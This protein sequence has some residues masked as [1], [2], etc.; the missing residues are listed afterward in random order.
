M[1]TKAA[2]DVWIKLLIVV[3]IYRFLINR[4][5]LCRNVKNNFSKKMLLSDEMLVHSLD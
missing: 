2:I 1:A 4:Q 3:N 5:L